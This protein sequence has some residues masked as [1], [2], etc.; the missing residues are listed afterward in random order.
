MFGGHGERTED[1][2]ILILFGHQI[3]EITAIAG[4]VDEAGH[5]CRLPRIFASIVGNISCHEYTQFLQARAVAANRVDRTT[6]I[7]ALLLR[8]QHHVSTVSRSAGELNGTLGLNDAPSWPDP[9][10]FLPAAAAR[11]ATPCRTKH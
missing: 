9:D 5:V 6:C 11:I 8:W 4:F 1:A 7:E 2:D 3:A 10:P